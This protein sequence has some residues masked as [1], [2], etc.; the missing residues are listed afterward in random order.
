MNGV[1]KKEGIDRI[2]KEEINRIRWK[3][4]IE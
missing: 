2:K 4:L 1:D 3:V